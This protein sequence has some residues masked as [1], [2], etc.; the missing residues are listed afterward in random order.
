MLETPKDR[1]WDVRSQVDA[2]TAELVALRRDPSVRKFL[3]LQERIGPTTEV[4]VEAPAPPTANW[5]WP[6]DLY[7]AF[8]F[9]QDLAGRQVST[10][11]L[12]RLAQGRFPSLSAADLHTLMQVLTENGSAEVVRMTD[13]GRPATYRFAPFRD[14]SLRTPGWRPGV[15]RN[16]LSGLKLEELEDI[17]G[18][19]RDD[20]DRL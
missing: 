2:W 19:S 7:D 9:A 14:G 12:S 11:A 8:E 18:P 3:E 17:V 10:R 15:P 13:T 16:E 20:W 1:A 6:Y 4:F 5:L